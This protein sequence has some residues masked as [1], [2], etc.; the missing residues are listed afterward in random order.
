MRLLFVTQTLDADHPVLAHTLGLVTA[1]AARAD[2]VVVL[3][4]RVGR[5]D[6]PANVRIRS[7]EA[8][9]RVRRGLRFL[10]AV[11]RES[12]RTDAVLAHMVPLF[13][14]LAAPVAAARRSRLLLWYTQG[15]AGRTL[16]LATRVAHVVLSADAQSFPLRT[17][18]VRAIGHAIDVE[19]FSPAPGGPPDARP[20]RLV[21][22]GRYAPVKGYATMLHGFGDA[23]EAGADLTLEIRG[24]ELTEVD[25]LHR[26]ELARMV[27]S[28]PTLRDRV[29]LG[30]P[31][32]HADVP[33]LL[34]AADALVSTTE[35]PGATT[36]DKVVC[37]AGA[38]GLPVIATNS[39]DLLDG[40]PL[41]LHVRPRDRAGL[42]AALVALAAGT[43]AERA[44]VGGEL[45]RRVVAGHS[46]DSWADAV[47]AA[48]AAESRQ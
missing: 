33:G 1:L 25:P 44:A 47:I 11:A 15:H 31:V 26:A 14:L 45:R 29:V 40:L 27:A 18:K 17:D 37:E 48:V 43:P 28:S 9:S 23:V 34:R 46:L 39:G 36:F 4:G 35:P 21:A 13:L 42:A 10:R 16:R 7:F 12:G 20:L 32:A 8:D 38:C 5:H 30:G 19:R 3:C 22:L 41:P 6:L 2:E 24:P